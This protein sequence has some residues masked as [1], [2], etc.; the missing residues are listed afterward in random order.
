VFAQSK[1]CLFNGCKCYCMM[2]VNYYVDCY[3]SDSTSI[4]LPARIYNASKQDVHVL[5]ITIYGYNQIEELP[6]NYLSNLTIKYIKM[7]KIEIKQ[8]N[9]NTFAG[10]KELLRL[11]LNENSTIGT[12]TSDAFTQEAQGIQFIYLDNNGMSG[13]TFAE[14]LPAFSKLTKLTQLDLNK[15]NIQNLP[16]DAFSGFK[17]SLTAADDGQKRHR[18]FCNKSNAI[19]TQHT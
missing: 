15:N 5:T 2:D 17:A 18:R 10:V 11:S 16:E 7:G 14:Y 3:G 4:T 12:I 9:K 13:S 8:I 6:A 1:V 19:R